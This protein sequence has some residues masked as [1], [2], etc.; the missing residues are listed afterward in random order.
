MGEASEVTQYLILYHTPPPRTHTHTHAKIRSNKPKD[1]SFH[2]S[3]H[4]ISLNFKAK[5][6]AP[7][8]YVILQLLYYNCYLYCL[9]Q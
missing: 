5:L 7:L 1:L 2:E 8:I 6:K 3:K 4:Q 9:Y